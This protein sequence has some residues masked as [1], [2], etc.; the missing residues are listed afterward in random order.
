MNRVA[1]DEPEANPG[2]NAAFDGA[3]PGIAAA[4]LN[5]GYGLAVI[6]GLL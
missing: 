4:R 5:P 6:P 1:W 2:S 3:A